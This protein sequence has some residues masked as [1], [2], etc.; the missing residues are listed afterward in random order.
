[1]PADF[2][3]FA[4][5][6]EQ[7][8]RRRGAESEYRFGVIKG[9]FEPFVLA[10]RY[11]QR[12]IEAGGDTIIFWTLD[13]LPADQAQA[14]ATR[15]AG[16]YETYRS[17]FG[18]LWKS[19]PPV[20]VIETP[21]RL[22]ERRG[23][24]GDAAGI[25]LPAGALLNRRAFAVGITSDTFLTLAEHE[26]AHTWFGEAIEARPRAEVVLGEALAEYST[27]VAAEARG[28]ESERQRQTALLLRW[29]D[30]S[31]KKAAD[32]PLLEIQAADPY[33]KR[34][35]GFSTGALFFVG[36][37]DRYGK[38]NVRHALAHLVSSLR[39]SRF[40]Y[41][42]LRAALELET[43][44]KLGDFFRL[45]LDETGIPDEFR[46]RYEVK[47]QRPESKE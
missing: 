37:E 46:A 28:G 31:R 23:G 36:L 39:G 41:V 6:R 29:F 8:S 27:L 10:G 25:A 11:Q 33:E 34:V 44:E 24:A 38:E 2:Q 15:L 17:A 21:A 40:G 32:K 16:T 47:E 18:Q 20:R 4:G 42:E 5:G 19:P 12:R 45:W 35:F 30:E 26:L 13:A 14:A 22:T 3:V 43:R 9:G 1:V 7:G